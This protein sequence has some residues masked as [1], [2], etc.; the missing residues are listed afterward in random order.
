LACGKPH[1]APARTAVLGDTTPRRVVHVFPRVGVAVR[2]SAGE[3]C[4]EFIIDSAAAPL[5]ISD[6]AAIVFPGDSGA[7]SLDAR[8]MGPHVG[9]CHAEFAQPRW[10]EYASYR[11]ELAST[12][13]AGAETPSV[14][15]IVVTNAKWTRDADGVT[16]ADLDGDGAREEVRRCRADEGEHFTI[17]STG[18]DNTRVRRWHEYYDWGAFTD[19]NCKPGEAGERNAVDGAK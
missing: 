10:D 5:R 14:A 16:R 8:V 4:A 13:A 6:H 11:V 12:P 1:D 3:W 17:W 15:L 9:Q 7:A 2:D 18:A 19:A